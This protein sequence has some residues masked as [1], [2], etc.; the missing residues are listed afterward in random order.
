VTLKN[1]AHNIRKLWVA[2]G[3]LKGIDRDEQNGATTVNGF[4][5]LHIPIVKIQVSIYLVHKAM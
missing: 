2:L 3:Q 5:V 1:A 4:S